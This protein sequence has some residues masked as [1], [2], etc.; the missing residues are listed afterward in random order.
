M[1][2]RY[3]STRLVLPLLTA[4][5][6]CMLVS[7]HV[8]DPW[9]GLTVNLAAAFLG[10]IVTILYVDVVLR[11][12]EEAMWKR[13]RSKVFMRLERVA[14][15]F[16]SSVRLGFGLKPPDSSIDLSRIR[17][18]LLRLAED[19]L[20][21]A[22]PGVERMD[23]EQ[24]QIFAR[25]LQG[26]SQE[27]DRILTLFSRNLNPD[28]TSSLLEIQEA[29]LG[30][31]GQYTTWPDLLGV[32]EQSLPLRKDGS[33]R[34]PYVRALKTL[35]ASDVEQLLAKCAQVLHSLPPQQG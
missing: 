26:L 9:E 24:W 7:K 31:L 22:R 10:S 1:N 33:S 23:Q 3:L 4:V 35:I 25:N 28:Y 18:E 27:V 14:N 17:R 2:L 11:H 6:V 15:G 32:P 8:P 13:V 5:A 16:I 21:P 12:H 19:V 29:A 30:I 34:V 20:V